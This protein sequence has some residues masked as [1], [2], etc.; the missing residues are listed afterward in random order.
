MRLASIGLA[1]CLAV[2]AAIAA[3]ARKPAPKAVK[4]VAK[5][6]AKGK[7][8]R[9]ARSKVIRVP[10]QTWRTRQT[11]PTKQRYLEIQQALYEQGYLTTEPT[12]VWNQEST[13]AV[14]DFQTD[15]KLS[16]TG[17][18]SALTLI[19]LGLGPSHPAAPPTLPAAQ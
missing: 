13:V 8:A 14:R 5:S 18:I 1:F 10:A 7:N 12:G 3:P 17:R 2:P 15:Q 9:G 6:P 4:T 16:V 19:S 11:A